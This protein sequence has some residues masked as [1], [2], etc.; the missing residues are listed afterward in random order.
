MILPGN[1]SNYM[2]KAALV[3]AAVMAL[4]L[5][6]TAREEGLRTKAYMDAAG[7]PTICY[8]ETEGVKMG[9]TATKEQCDAIFYIRLGFYAYMVDYYVQP[10][11]KPEFH[12]ALTSW[13]YNAGINAIRTSKSVTGRANAGDFRGACQGLL[14]W[15]YAAGKPILLGRRIRERDQLCLKGV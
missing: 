4:A 9:D 10:P 11:M 15:K 14:N 6:F 13:G 1:L 5:P 7:V 3:P 2:K 12:A 8:G